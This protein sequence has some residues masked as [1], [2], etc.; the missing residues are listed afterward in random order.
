MLFFAKK[1]FLCFT[2]LIA[3]GNIVADATVALATVAIATKGAV[4]LRFTKDISVISR[5]LRRQRDK[6]MEPL[7]MKSLHA[8]FLLEVCRAP[9]ITQ[10]Q[11]TQL[12]GFD[13][14]SVARHAAFLEEQGYLSR[15][16]GADKRVLQ[17]QP[18]EKTLALEPEL[19]KQMNLWEQTVLQDLS[20]EEQK[21]LLELLRRVRIRAE[22]E[23]KHG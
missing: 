23:E 19:T 1:G 7:G 8:R 9:G 21:T 3:C 17:L 4:Q 11:L 20:P 14:S 5:Y 15:Q 10:D 13:K 2:F 22:Q 18:T 16:A 6:Y 12:L